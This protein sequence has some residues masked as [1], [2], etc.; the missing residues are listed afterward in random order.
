MS[1]DTDPAGAVLGAAPASWWDEAAQ[2]ADEAE[3]LRHRIVG[4]TGRASRH[5]GGHD[6]VLGCQATEAGQVAAAGLLGLRRL[7]AATR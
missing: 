2:L 1:L 5:Y 7:L 4:L 3:A 6:S